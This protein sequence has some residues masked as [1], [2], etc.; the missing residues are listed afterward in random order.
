ML[1]IPKS[2]QQISNLHRLNIGPMYK[3]DS[4]DMMN[5]D[6]YEDYVSA[7]REELH[8]DNPDL[9]VYCDKDEDMWEM[10]K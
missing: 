6:E 3:K 4:T 1:E 2:K 5:D 8:Q 9:L 7:I 10:Y